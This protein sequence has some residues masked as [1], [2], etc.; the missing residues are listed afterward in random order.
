MHTTG[1]HLQHS[2]AS[3]KLKIIKVAT[4]VKKC[5]TGRKYDTTES[6]TKGCVT[7]VMSWC[8]AG[9]RSTLIQEENCPYMFEN[10]C[11]M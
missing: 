11:L 2:N 3:Q 1:T 8:A 7:T 5:I 9:K 10:G 4:R 6:C